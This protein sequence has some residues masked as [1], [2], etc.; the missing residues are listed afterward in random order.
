MTQDELKLEIERLEIL[1]KQEDMQ[2]RIN[3]KQR[4]S[5]RNITSYIKSLKDANVLKL[6][7]KVIENDILKVEK[8]VGKLAGK[9]KKLYELKLKGLKQELKYNQDIVKSQT[10][11]SQILRLSQ[12]YME[13]IVGDVGKAELGFGRLL[14]Y[15]DESN[16]VIKQ[17]NLYLGNTGGMA[18]QMSSSIQA[19]AGYAAQLGLSL[20]EVAKLQQVYADETGKAVPLTQKI[21]K[22]VTDL[23]QGTGLGVEN[24]S[25]LYAGYENVGGSLSNIS[26]ILENTVNM[27][28]KF[29]INTTKMLKTVQSKMELMNKFNFQNGVKG[30]ANMV[31]YAQRMKVDLDGIAQAMDKFSSIDTAIEA[32]AKLQALGG[33]FANQDVFQLGFLARNK[34]EEFIAQMNAMTKGAATFNKEAGEFQVS[35]LQMDRLKLAAEATG[36]EYPKL[37]EQAKEFAKIQAISSKTFGLNKDQKLL[38]AQM[39]QFNKGTGK[40]EIDINGQAIDVAKV[41]ASQVA[42]LQGVTKTMEER[43]KDAQNF[44][45]LFGNTIMEMKA[46]LLPLLTQMNYVLGGVR[47]LVDGVRNATKDLNPMIQQLLVIGTLG[48]VIGGG[49]KLIGSLKSITGMLPKLGLGNLFGGLKGGAGGATKDIGGLSKGLAGIPSQQQLLG[50]AA[51]IA[52]IGVAAAGIGA[53]VYMASKGLADLV[54]SFKGLTDKQMLAALTGV[55]LGMGGFVAALAIAGN[56][57]ATAL[58]GLLGISAA[59]LSIGGGI[60][61]A[62]NGLATF[63][64]SLQGVAKAQGA[65]DVLMSVGKGVGYMSAA[66]LNP[67]FIPNLAAFGIFL[68]SV[69]GVD[70]TG[71]DKGFASVNTFL[72]ANPRNFELLKSTIDSLDKIDMSPLGQIKELFSKPLKVEFDQKTVNLMINFTAMI[73]GDVLAKR[74]GIAEK[75]TIGVNRIRKG[76]GT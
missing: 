21:F 55:A 45:K 72:Q 42:V 40:F 13:K 58:P 67:L 29:G 31:Q 66:F 32:T 59:A 7:N 43:A 36:Q 17:L 46:V 73:D 65:G 70:L 41:Q 11:S 68:N 76:L 71:L 19:S 38:V 6:K 49:I 10:S 39:A 56:V 27:N 44:D 74:M 9:E 15:L 34:P 64:N 4:E 50:K 26:A 69:K 62:A 33:S 12:S 1:R 20:E 52:A 35:A 37:V 5:S 57:S 51:G 25:A 54:A 75:A 30:L 24:A 48:G 16:G 23:A 22:N 63:N 14:H 53:G 8:I 61:M 28:S 2:E 3:E 47:S 18:E 60:W